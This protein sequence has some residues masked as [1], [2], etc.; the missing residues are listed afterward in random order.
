MKKALLVGVV[1]FF[2]LPTLLL[3]VGAALL[4]S[5][6]AT[7][8]CGPAGPAQ[9]VVGVSLD[10]EQLANAKTIVMTTQA[11]G[12]LPRAAVVA[13]ATALQESG[14]RNL[15]H[16]DRDSLGLFQQRASWAAADVRLNPVAAT[17][18]FLKA[19]NAVPQ[20]ELLPVTVAS[21]QV[22]HSAFPSAVARWESVAT[23]LV[24]K[25]WP[26]DVSSSTP[27]STSVATATTS[28]ATRAPS[29]TSPGAPG[30]PGASA[31]SAASADC[32]GQGGEGS[33]R[34]GVAKL[35][36]DF[37]LP[38]QAQQRAVLRFALAQ[39]GKPYVWGGTGPDGWDCSGLSMRAWGA[40]GVPV[41][42]TTFQQVL[43]GAPVPS[44]AAMQ[45][46]DLIFIAGSDGTP[47][48]PG[49]MGLYV[50]LVNAQPYLVH[51]PQTG[52]TVEIKPVSAWRDQI[53]AIRRPAANLTSNP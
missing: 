19:L 23:P 53:V 21:D 51:A 8:A 39:L 33:G 29:P 30:A 11:A 34:G 40:A 13:V 7:S 48:N 26:V 2:A 6:T 43:V 12:Q 31:G 9:R 3:I 28:T 35:P 46:G 49:H 38:S 17:I 52:K 24:S 5:A 44:T 14:L 16:G 10:P 42:R 25:Y 18:L 47:S 32:P 50:G 1:A 41:P 22:Q 37:A 20:W 27:P 4:S 15:P 45:P 36:S